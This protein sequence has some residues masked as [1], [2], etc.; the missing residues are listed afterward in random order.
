MKSILDR[1]VKSWVH[2]LLAM[3]LAGCAPSE[4]PTPTLALSECR[5]QGI[6]SAVRCATLMVD[7]DR[8]NPGNRRIPIHVVVLPATSRSKAADPI[9]FFAGGPSQ[10]ASDYAR[11]AQLM[12]AGLAA[13]RDIVLID[14]RG[15][16]KSNGL[17]CKSGDPWELARLDA[18]QR[19]ARS[20][21]LLRTCREELASKADLT[22][23]TT[24]LAM[25][26]VDAVRDAL[27]YREI[28]LWGG[29]YGTR[30]AQEYLRRYPDRVRS[31]VLDGVAPPE[32]A[33]P[34]NFSNDAAAALQRGFDAC[35]SDG[36]CSAR[37]GELQREAF[38]LLA[39]LKARPASPVVADPLDGAPHQIHVDDEAL[40]AVLFAALYAPET[41]ALLPMVVARAA[42][43][44]FQPFA[45]LSAL[46]SADAEDKHAM[47]MRL[48][49]VCTED[50]PR[51]DPASSS[52]SLPFRDLFVREFL[53]S[54]EGW[55]RGSVDA[56]FHTPV[57]STKPVLILSGALDPVTPPAFGEL[58][59]R[60]LSN[61]VHLVAPAI[62]HGVSG[63]GCAPKLVK[64]FIESASAAGLN[65]ECLA[66][67]PRPTFFVPP[68]RRVADADN[69]GAR[70]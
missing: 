31:V 36:A 30:A 18:R 37:Y 17:F 14:Q 28:N 11:Q 59:K 51:L 49:V 47:G 56:Q 32:L 46:L 63:R 7:E 27:G 43:G 42:E 1:R 70:K 39:R 68:M 34:A 44:D 67:I 62:G 35:R 24:T 57:R 29:S 10:A 65:G 20:A 19:A 48:S 26:D 6:E 60:D 66:R 38:G 69:P 40:A 4:T 3:L 23:Y 45:T 13:K 25:A 53:R 50:I 8:A 2:P 52:G 64:Q 58:V 5:V 33:L 15:T 61:A 22:K 12:F 21:A 9:F 16:G 41:T 55:P 54:C